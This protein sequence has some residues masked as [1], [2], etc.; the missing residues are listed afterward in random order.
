MIVTQE[1]VNE[2]NK[3]FNVD[4]LMLV[5][6][7]LMNETYQYLGKAISDVVFIPTP[8]EID[9]ERWKDNRNSIFWLKEELK[10]DK[11]DVFILTNIAV[12]TPLMDIK[13][14]KMEPLKTNMLNT[15]GSIYKTGEIYN[16]P[17][18][19]DPM[20]TFKDTKLAIADEGIL[21]YKVEE[22]D[23]KLILE[24]PK[25]PLVEAKVKY[26]L[27]HPYSTVFKINNLNL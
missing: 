9:W 3:N 21:E 17:V 11:K 14:F 12:G 26:K 1:Q 19:V 2:L 8:K 7:V 15:S 24:G 13:D 22:K 4:L 6:N 23:L 5:E 16:T 20:L 27:G 10:K 18:Y 25:A